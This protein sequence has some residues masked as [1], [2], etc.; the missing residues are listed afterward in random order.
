MLRNTSRLLSFYTWT[1]LVNLGRSDLGLNPTS[2]LLVV[3]LWEKR[4]ILN[5]FVSVSEIGLKTIFFM[6]LRIK[7]VGIVV[8]SIYWPPF[9][10]LMLA[11]YVHSHLNFTKLC[12]LIILLILLIATKGRNEMSDN[13]MVKL[14]LMC[15]SIWNVMQMVF[16][17]DLFSYLDVGYLR[18]RGLSI[19]ISDK[20][21]KI[22]LEKLQN[23]YC[24]NII[25]MI[26]CIIF[27]I[28]YNKTV[29]YIDC[30]NSITENFIHTQR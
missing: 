6:L 8:G 23:I 5:F 12:V 9:V 28:F 13:R 11:F 25:F 2:S 1:R 27:M 4:D 18:Y 21:R 30:C 22:E 14:W 3:S 15:F 29:T 26:F 17:E 24:S 20:G 19:I 7:R 10:C 16:W